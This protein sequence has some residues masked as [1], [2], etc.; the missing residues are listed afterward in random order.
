MRR[1]GQRAVVVCLITQYFVPNSAQWPSGASFALVRTHLD[2]G[3]R[4]KQMRSLLYLAAVC[5][6]RRRNVERG[7]S[8]LRWAVVAA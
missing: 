2:E 7:E 6:T 8:P 3:E 1:L 5:A 4:A